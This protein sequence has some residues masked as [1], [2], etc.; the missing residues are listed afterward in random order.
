[1]V[2]ESLLPVSRE[3]ILM[4]RDSAQLTEVA[5][6]LGKGDQKLAVVC[7]RS[8]AMVGVVSKTDIVSRIGECQ[9]HAC[10][11]KVATV[12]IRD[13]TYCRPDDPLQEVWS[14]MKD[15]GLLNF[16]IVDERD[17]PLG[18]LNA[19]ANSLLIES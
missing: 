4:I 11:M 2:V 19:R 5:A 14:R 7:D 17:H 18:V 9:G 10:A 16:P 12:M 15:K 8:G 1:M 3:R 13:V 6:L